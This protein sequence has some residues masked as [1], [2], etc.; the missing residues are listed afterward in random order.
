MA[1]THEI[2]DTCPICM[3]T[4]LNHMHCS[5]AAC[6]Y[7]VTFCPRCDRVQAVSKFIADH[8]KDC[9][10]A[11]AVPTATSSAAFRLPVPRR[12]AA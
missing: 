9:I 10:H 5:N 4:K 6:T 1:S 2:K 8:E 7:A 3:E 11:P 12:D